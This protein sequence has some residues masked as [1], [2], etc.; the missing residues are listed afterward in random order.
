[1]VPSHDL[2][3]GILTKKRNIQG[4]QHG[5]PTNNCQSSDNIKLKSAHANE[6]L[7]TVRHKHWMDQTL[8][9]FVAEDLHRNKKI[10]SQH[11]V[12][13]FLVCL[14]RRVTQ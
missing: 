7:T 11:N 12:A 2:L 3:F 1:M 6:L 8:E 9:T 5:S 14:T 10:K 13:T 4:L